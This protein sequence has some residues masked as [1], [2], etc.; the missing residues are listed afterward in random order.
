M[1]DSHAMAEPRTSRI[2]AVDWVRGLVMVIMALDH[3]REFFTFLPLGVNPEDPLKA[4]PDLFFTRWITHFCARRSCCSPAGAYLYGARGQSRGELAWFLFSRGLWLIVLELTWVRWAALFNLDYH[5]SFVQVIWAI[6]ASMVLLSPCVFLPTGAV[7][8]IGLVIVVGH[9]WLA[10]HPEYQY[11]PPM[12]WDVLQV[13]RPFVIAP[14]YGV[15]NVYPLLAWIGALTGYGFGWIL[16][17]DARRRP[18]VL[19]LGITMTLGFIVL[20]TSS[21]RRPAPLGFATRSAA[22]CDGISGVQQI[23]AV[24]AISF[25]D[26]RPRAHAASRWSMGRAVRPCGYS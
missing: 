26:A 20:R 4:D 9:N 23:P 11:G 18:I 2:D 25:D 13:Q 15:F 21:L 12:L 1:A 19:A 7:A 6:G 16:N 8:A 5:F 22:Q 10:V 24:A 3:T 17:L 14:G